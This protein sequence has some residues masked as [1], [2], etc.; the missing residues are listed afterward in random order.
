MNSV[1]PHIPD[2]LQRIVSRC[3]RKNPE[4]RYPTATLVAEDLE[5]LRRDT[6]ANLAQRTSW[7][8]R[9]RDAL[10]GLRQQPPAR[11]MW[12]GVGA[13][14]LL[15]A[16]V[17]LLVARSV[18]GNA[19]PLTLAGLFI[20]RYVRNQP[21]RLQG[22]FVRQ[23][24]KVPEVRLVVFRSG[25]FDVVVDRAVAQLYGRLNHQLRVCNQKLFFGQPLTLSILH[26]LSGEQLDKLLAGPGVQY[27]RPDV[28][29]QR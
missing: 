9:L 27:V 2:A 1:R 4:E 26:D 14:V 5:R 17:Y 21:H 6:E 19:V 23:A 18:M 15:S 7:R 3:L 22:S 28:L 10:E 12:Y 24:A 16:L 8:Q 20:Y 11:L 29:E 25:Q 13:L